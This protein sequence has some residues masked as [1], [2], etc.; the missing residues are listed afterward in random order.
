MSVY[1][2]MSYLLDEQP[3]TRHVYDTPP[4]VERAS[5]WPS[6]RRNKRRPQE[7]PALDPCVC[8]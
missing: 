4:V 1:I 5:R 3:G 8:G 6:L 7:R 2:P